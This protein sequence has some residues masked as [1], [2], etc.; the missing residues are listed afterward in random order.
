MNFLDILGQLQGKPATG[1]AG[2]DGARENVRGHLVEGG[3][4]PQHFIRIDNA[5]GSDDVGQDWV[6]LG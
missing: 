1:A 4:E 3:C 5:A 6:S 2:Y